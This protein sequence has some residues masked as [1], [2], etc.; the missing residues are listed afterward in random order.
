MTA[1]GCCYFFFLQ[2]VFRFR[3]FGQLVDVYKVESLLGTYLANYD[4]D[5]VQRTVM[6]Y[7]KGSVWKRIPSPDGAR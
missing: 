5:G 4:P 1:V 6:S 2:C 7:N 3:L